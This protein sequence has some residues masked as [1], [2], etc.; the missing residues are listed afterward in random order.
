MSLTKKTHKIGG[1]TLIIV[2]L[3]DIYILFPL[4][5]NHESGTK[6]HLLM[7]ILKKNRKIFDWFSHKNYLSQS[8]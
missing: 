8:A 1:T 6:W 7:M 5:L 2:M 3:V 4:L